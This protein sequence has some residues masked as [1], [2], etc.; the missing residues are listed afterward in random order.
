MVDLIAMFLFAREKNGEVRLGLGGVEVADLGCVGA[1][2]VE[3]KYCLSRVLLS[4]MR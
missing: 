1:R 4:R 2:D 3:H